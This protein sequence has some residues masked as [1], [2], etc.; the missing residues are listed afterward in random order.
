MDVYLIVEG[1][2]ESHAEEV[3]DKEGVDDVSGGEREGGREGGAVEAVGD[4]AWESRRRK[5]KRE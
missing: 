3:G 4:A 1:A 2:G 5:S